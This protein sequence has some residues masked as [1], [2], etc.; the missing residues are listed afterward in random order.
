MATGASST[1]NPNPTP[2][3]TATNLNDLLNSIMPGFGNL[4]SGANN[5]VDD[6]LQGLPSPDVTQTQNAYFGAQNGLPP[7]ADFLRDRGYDLY[8]QQ[9]AARKQQG[10]QDFGQLLGGYT[11]LYGANNQSN[12]AQSS[13]AQQGN[14]FNQTNSLNQQQLDLQR[15]QAALNATNSTNPNTGF[16]INPAASRFFNV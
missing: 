14:Q 9:A 2:G 8:G 3:R 1:Y 6:M 15:R 10:V 13:L 11:N 5:V 7:G 16:N 4:A 12:Q